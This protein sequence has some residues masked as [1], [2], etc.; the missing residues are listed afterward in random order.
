MVEVMHAN[1]PAHTSLLPDVHVTPGS[2]TDQDGYRMLV[3]QSIVHFRIPAMRS[4]REMTITLRLRAHVP[5]PPE[6]DDTIQPLDY[7][8]YYPQ[9][10]WSRWAPKI[11][12]N[13]TITFLPEEHRTTLT[14]MLI[15][16]PPDAR[17]EALVPQCAPCRVE[18]DDSVH[19]DLDGTPDL[20][21]EVHLA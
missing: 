16:P 20:R 17:L 6:H 21:A 19:Y 4:G 13:E 9:A 10:W 7:E 2:S 14:I 12:D 8:I 1:S 3:L 18:S 15:D 11:K 5:V